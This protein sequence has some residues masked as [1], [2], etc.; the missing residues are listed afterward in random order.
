VYQLLLILTLI[1]NLSPQID[2]EQN[3]YDLFKVTYIVDVPETSVT[4]PVSQADVSMTSGAGN[5]EV[6]GRKVSPSEGEAFKNVSVY[7]RITYIVDGDT[8]H[9]FNA[10]G[11]KRKFRPIGIN[12]PETGKRNGRPEP[13]HAEATAFTKEM[14]LDHTVRI[15]YDVTELDRYGR[16][17]VYVYLQ[18]GTFFNLEVVRAG[19]ARTMTIA[20]NVKYAELFSQAQ[21]EAREQ[22]RGSWE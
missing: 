6:D 10:E 5:H 7:W 16:H 3:E 2:Q 15:V 14:L 22:G 20:P 17:L 8:F 21:R 4:H 1:F 19:W 9:G 11:E 12:T 18:D 13:F